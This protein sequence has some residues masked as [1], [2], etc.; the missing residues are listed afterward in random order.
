MSSYA[1]PTLNNIWSLFSVNFVS[2]LNYLDMKHSKLNQ[3][4]LVNF[5]VQCRNDAQVSNKEDKIWFHTVKMRQKSLSQEV[6]KC[7][8][9]NFYCLSVTLWP[10]PKVSVSEKVIDQS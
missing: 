4:L 3:G 5:I 6:E 8:P 9:D 7:V 10:D 2:P 1:F